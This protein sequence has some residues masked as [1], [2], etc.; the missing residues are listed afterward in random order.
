MSQVSQ[1]N[2]QLKSIRKD[3]KEAKR[4]LKD[5]KRMLNLNSKGGTVRLKSGG[6]V[7]DSYDY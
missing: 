6:N 5:M 7:I 2:K 3:K 1:L 4:E